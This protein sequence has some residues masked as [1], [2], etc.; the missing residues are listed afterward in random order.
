MLDPGEDTITFEHLPAYVRPRFMQK[1]KYSLPGAQADG[2][3]LHKILEE[4][5]R[6]VIEK[7]LQANQGN[8]TRSARELGLLR[9]NLQYRMRR[10]GIKAASY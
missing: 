10:L 1:R 3:T 4:T 7:V 5:E 2:G 8:I 9:Q 6:Q